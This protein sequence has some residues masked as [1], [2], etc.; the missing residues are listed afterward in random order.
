MTRRAILMPAT[1]VLLM[2]PAVRTAAGSPPADGDSPGRIQALVERYSDTGHFSGCALVARGDQVL[3]RGS[4]GLANREWRIPHTDDTR[5]MIGSLSKAF[6][7]V[8]VLQLIQEGKLSLDTP[9][10]DGLS[11]FPRERGARITIR[12]LLTHTSG[13]GNHGQ[14]PAFEARLERLRHDRAEMIELIGGMGLLF[15]P[16]ERFGYSS[17]GYDLLAFVCERLEGRPF[18]EVLER[19]IFAPAGMSHTSL[20]DFRTVEERRAAGYEYD[21]VP[22]FENASFVDGSNV[23][24]GG[25]ILSTVDDLHRWVQALSGR[26]LLPE[27]WRTEMLGTQVA[28]DADSGYGYGW[29]VSGH[30]DRGGRQVWHTGS[31]NGFT[32]FISWVPGKDDLVI[33]LSNVRSN[34]LGGN[35]RYKLATLEKD[36]RSIL[37]GGPGVPP[38]RSAVMTISP[39]AVASGGRAAVEA[40]RRLGRGHAEEHYFDELELNALGL[41]LLF[42]RNRADDA[43]TLLALNIEEHPRSYNVYDTMGYVLRKQGRADDALACYRKGIAVFDADPVAN[44]VYRSDYEKAV[45]L[46]SESEA[47]SRAGG[48]EALRRDTIA[49]P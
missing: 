31:T 41:Q 34:V 18:A 47:A 36:I 6:T 9:L 29:F 46:V 40:Y 13:L 16:G 1:V 2:L 25:G 7:A 42:G 14:V 23:V 44:E 32:S 21:L 11:G 28:I 10:S 15:E 45:K 4:V 22:G 17:F 24:G 5:F 3:Y 12:H 48:R 38:R 30:P 20:T 43:L 39:V 37:A 26:R 27:P 33:L 8:V 19:R 49:A 35:H